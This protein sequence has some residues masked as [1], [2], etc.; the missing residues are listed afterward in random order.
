MVIAI[1]GS[2]Y[3]D[4]NDLI[5]SGP[6]HFIAETQYSY[7]SNLKEKLSIKNTVI[8]LDFAVQ[9]NVQRYY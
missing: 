7:I 9:D 4:N 1:D 8:F 6:I 3:K 2:S 5:R